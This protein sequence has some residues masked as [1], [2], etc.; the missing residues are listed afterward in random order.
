MIIDTAESKSAYLRQ[1]EKFRQGR[2][3]KRRER[4]LHIHIKE[5]CTHMRETGLKKEE[6]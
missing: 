4:N 1:I 6:E 3:N 2:T 5:M